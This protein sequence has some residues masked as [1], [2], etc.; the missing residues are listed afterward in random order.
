[1]L[2]HKKLVKLFEKK[3]KER[4][5]RKENVLFNQLAN[6]DI[7]EGVDL[8]SLVTTQIKVEKFRDAVLMLKNNTTFTKST[9]SLQVAKQ[10]RGH[11]HQDST[12]KP[13]RS[14]SLNNKNKH[15]IDAPPRTSRAKP[16]TLNSA[17]DEDTAAGPVFRGAGAIE[18]ATTLAQDQQLA[19][20][21][22]YKTRGTPPSKR[23]VS[24]S[25]VSAAN[26]QDT[27][28]SKTIR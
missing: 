12:K 2:S 23:R 15:P 17:S 13:R 25:S 27:A 9:Y 5:T 14:I 19:W 16:L 21:R 1:M 8:A 3:V 6:Y 10:K 4:F 28:T 24:T 18:N 7:S 11:A 22:L 20:Y 26:K